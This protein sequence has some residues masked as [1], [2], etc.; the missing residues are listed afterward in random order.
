MSSP[1]LLEISDLGINFGGVKALDGVN[2]T[3]RSGESVGLIGPN[4]A[5]K[6]TLINCISRTFGHYTGTV[7]LDGVSLNG[8]KPETLAR[9]GLS[10]TFQHVHLF[11]ELTVEENVLV[12]MHHTGK[13]GMASY[14]LGLAAARREEATR[15][16]EA[17]AIL[18]LLDLDGI[19]DRRVD[20]LPFPQQRRVDI[21]RALASRPR[22]L[23]LDEPAAG[24]NDSE[25]N[26][27]TNFI[28]GLKGGMGV[29]AI[30]LIEHH[31]DMV[32]RLCDHIAVLDFGRKIADGTPEDIRS[33]QKVLDAYLGGAPL[34]DD[35]AK[36]LS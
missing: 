11:T 36:E 32:M 30:V 13:I 3:V 35:D 24:L 9:R 1:A 6:T 18:A 23:L 27:L 26:E 14:A 12:G 19:A 15:R 31:V 29:E 28:A 4:G 16:E 21:A 22:L 10:R 7:T 33:D 8:S 2:L 5:G 17:R 34:S 20:T 25:T